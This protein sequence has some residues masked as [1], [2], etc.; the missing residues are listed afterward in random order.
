[1]NSL[2]KALAGLFVLATIFVAFSC[3]NA[4]ESDDD[5][6]PFKGTTWKNETTGMSLNFI[7]SETCTYGM[8]SA[9]FARAM[10]DVDIPTGTYS[11]SWKEN[12]DGSYTAT[13]E[14]DGYDMTFTIDSSGAVSGTFT[15]NGTKFTFN[16]E[17]DKEIEISGD[18]DG[19]PFA[20]TKW[21]GIGDMEGDEIS[22]GSSTV[23]IGG[24]ANGIPY[25]S[26]EDD[27]G[28]TAT[29]GMLDTVVYTFKIESANAE[30]GTLTE[31]FGGE[32][33]EMGT[34]KR[35]NK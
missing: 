17:V 27:E 28:Y 4:S 35:V 19:Y 1:M 10:S 33:Y 34:Y 22:F 8:S 2:K 16:K 20:G 11:Y 31:V 7:S 15:V 23:V 29:V 21:E 30:E 26:K 5:G 3:S 24:A 13:L 25:T 12:D 32:S 14:L 9:K 18:G 6:N